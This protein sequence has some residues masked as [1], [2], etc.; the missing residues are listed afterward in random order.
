MSMDT[1]THTQAFD[2]QAIE[3]QK[4]NEELIEVKLER[5]RYMEQVNLWRKRAYK[6]LIIALVTALCLVATSVDAREYT[7][8]A[9]LIRIVD[10]DT[11]VMR[12]HVYHG[13]QLI[14]HVRLADWDTPEY[15]GKCQREKDLALQAAIFAGLW[16]DRAGAVRATSR[17]QD[18]FGR[19]L[20]E[21]MSADGS[22]GL[23]LRDA[24][25][26]RPFK[27]GRN[28]GWCDE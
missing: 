24:G 28:E 2:P 10:G 1:Y 19:P 9:D 8:E 17:Q 26:A 15:R 16:F 7:H 21:L 23:A 3:A 4:R 22:L 14:Q 5:N 6:W 25:L 18:A 11:Y 12:L 20:S 27:R 13:A